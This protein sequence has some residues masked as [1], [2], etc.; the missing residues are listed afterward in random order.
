MGKAES[1]GQLS[2]WTDTTLWQVLQGKSSAESAHVTATLNGCMPDI[3][4]TL[5][6][7]GTAPADF[8]LHDSQHS[9][10]VAERMAS[11]IPSDVLPNLSAY[12]LAL[13]LLSAY[14]HDIGMTPEQHKVSAH[15]GYLLTG[16]S[17]DLSKKEINE[18]QKWL[19]DNGH[20]IVPPLTKD[21]PNLDTVRLAN[22]LTAHYCRHRHNDWSEV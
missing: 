21:Q 19:D 2:N 22:E 14:L 11:L 12:E 9:F 6:Q 7:G 16:N 8:T 4:R 17:A 20:D 10:R 1:P 15:Y 13:L 18:F 5:A 3:Q